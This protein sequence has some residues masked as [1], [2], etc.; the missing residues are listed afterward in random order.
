MGQVAEGGVCE[1]WG[2]GFWTLAGHE[3]SEV[4]PGR[5]PRR[6]RARL[7]GIDPRLG[8]ALCGTCSTRLPL[9]SRMSGWRMRFWRACGWLRWTAR[10]RGVDQGAV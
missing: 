1:A 7:G 10:A 5:R 8:E 3:D 6:R 9:R 4:L 2:A